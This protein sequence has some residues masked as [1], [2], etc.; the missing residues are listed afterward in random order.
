MKESFKK[1][2]KKTL[3]HVTHYVMKVSHK[4]CHHQDVEIANSFAKINNIAYDLQKLI[5][6]KFKCN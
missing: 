6:R 3:L 5:E 2:T 1:P 4:F